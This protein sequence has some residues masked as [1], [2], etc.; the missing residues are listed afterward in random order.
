MSRLSF[1]V[2]NFFI[3]FHLFLQNQTGLGKLSCTH[4]VFRMITET[5][6]FRKSSC[7]AEYPHSSCSVFLLCFASI[8]CHTFPAVFI[9]RNY[10]IVFLQHHPI[11]KKSTENISF[12]LFVYPLCPVCGRSFSGISEFFLYFCQIFN[13]QLPVQV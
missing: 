11:L 12:H 4:P 6:I 13:N 3:F 8:I 5:G 1:T 7:H 10:L 2:L 9:C